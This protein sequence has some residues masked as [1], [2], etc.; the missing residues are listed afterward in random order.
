MARY[1]INPSRS[2]YKQ[3]NIAGSLS[4]DLNI[5][6]EG[7]VFGTLVDESSSM[8]RREV[9]GRASRTSL[10]F[11]VFVPGE[12]FLNLKYRLKRDSTSQTDDIYAGIWKGV[13]LPVEK[14]VDLQIT[15]GPVEMRNGDTCYPCKITKLQ[16]RRENMREQE[17]TLVLEVA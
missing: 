2:Q 12:E 6:N 11:N 3:D 8:S 1:R 17:V 15:G 13:W 14:R 4:G 9:K 5:T 10:D 7:L 16:P